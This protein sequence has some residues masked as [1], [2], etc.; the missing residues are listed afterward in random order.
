M[1]EHRHLV[2]SASIIT[3]ITILSR[4][5]GYIRDQRIAFLLGTGTAADAFTIAYRI[6]NL[7]RRLVGEGAVSAAFIPV[8][9]RYL[10]DEDREEA[11]DFANALFTILTVFLAS[12]TVLGIVFSPLIVK[13]LAYGFVVTP[14]KIELTT[15]LNRIMFPYIF[16]IGLSALSMGVLNSFHRFAAPAFAPVLLNISVIVFSFLTARFSDE[17]LALAV[18]VVVGGILQVAIQLPYLIRSG[19]RWRLRLNWAHP[20]VRQVARLML[21][22]LFGVGIV[23][24]NILVD[25]QFASLLEEG[26]VMSLYLADRVMELVLG[27]YAIAL[28][29][30]ILPLMSRQAAENRID[31]MKSTLNFASRLVLFITIPSTA[32]LI[33]LREPIIEVLFE[34]GEFGSASTVLTAW[35]L[36]FFAIGLSAFSMVKIIVPAF[37]ALHDTRT[38]VQVAFVAMFLNIGFNLLFIGPLQN[39]GPALA[40]SLSAFF[41]A[42]ALMA[43]FHRRFGSFDVRLILQSLAKFSLAALTLAFG[44]HTLVGLPGFYAGQAFGQRVLTLIL[45][46]AA[47]SGIYFLAAFLLRCRELEELRDLVFRRG[48]PRVGT[49]REEPRMG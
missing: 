23:Q 8:F 45:V 17:S 12:V 15:L 27:G 24:V 35:P 6:P 18:G 5:F 36:F 41:N 16:F 10:S 42:L 3:A 9:S 46:I 2:K 4:I 1:S 21:P 14:G 40:T 38:P 37:Y 28:S 30:A 7:L 47:A 25:S 11:W 19:W 44:A 34:H 29:T 43:I 20:G 39:G 49:A 31:Q 33:I 48:T 13:L 32:G 26:S 22:V